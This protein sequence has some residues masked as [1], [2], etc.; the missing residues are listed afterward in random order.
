MHRL[1]LGEG[2]LPVT[3][4]IRMLPDDIIIGVEI[5]RDEPGIDRPAR[6][7]RAF[8]TPIAALRAAA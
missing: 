6:A 4:F 5:S 2:Q 8:E 3:D 7:A 1:C